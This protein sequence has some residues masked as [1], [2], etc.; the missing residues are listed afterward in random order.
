[1][2]QRLEW[3]IVTDCATKLTKAKAK[4]LYDNGYRYVGRYLTGTYNGGISKAITREEAQIIFDAGLRFFPIFQTAAYY[5]EYFTP[6]KGAIDAQKATDAAKA[7]GLPKNTIIYFA[8]DFDSNQNNK[9]T[10]SKC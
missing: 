8:V 10:Y 5:L 2:R 3:V 9:S 4:T 6:Q 7:L 1:M